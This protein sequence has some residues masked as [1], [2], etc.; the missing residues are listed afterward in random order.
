MSECGLFWVDGALFWVGGGGWHCMGHYFGWVDDEQDII[1]GG[2]R[3][4]GWMR[5]SGGEWK[6]AYYLI[7]PKINYKQRH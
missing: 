2:W 4:W 1:L 3:G 5:M 7:I 6:W